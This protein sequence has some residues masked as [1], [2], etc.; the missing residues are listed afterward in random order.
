MSAK[1][2]AKDVMTECQDGNGIFKANPCTPIAKKL[3]SK[4]IIRTTMNSCEIIA[5]KYS[6]EKY[7]NS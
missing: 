5:V 7:Q 4:I 1:G 2:H 6:Q 3:S